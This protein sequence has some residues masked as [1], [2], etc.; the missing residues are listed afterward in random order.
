MNGQVNSKPPVRPLWDI[1]KTALRLGVTSFGGPVAHLGF[2]RQEYVERK[3]WLNDQ[4]YGEI[5]AI[6]QV[7]PGPTSSQVGMAIGL[8][9]GGWKGALLAWLGFTA[10]SALALML[11]AWVMEGFH[12]HTVPLVH[13]FMLVAAAVVAQAVWS[14]ARTLAADQSRG[15]LAIVAAAMVLLWPTALGQISAIILGGFGGLLLL[16]E[17]HAAPSIKG[18]FQISKTA[19]LAAF[20]LFLLLLFGLPVLH[21]LVPAQPVALFD[22]FYR[23]GS[24]VYGGGHVV[25][26][27]LQQ[28]VVPA[29]WLSNDEFLAGYGAAQAIPG[30]L[31]T[32]AAFVGFASHVAPGG[33]VGGLLALVA[34]FLPGLLLITAALPLYEHLHT[35]PR[36]RKALAGVNAAVVG[37]LGAALYNPVW[38]SA[39]QRPA[40]LAVILAAFGLLHLWKVPPWLVVVGCAVLGSIAPSL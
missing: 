13:G 9:R 4:V 32:F 14:M 16:R 31:F 8:L 15:T 11:F 30:P 40:D 1:F 10:P 17:D 21:W 18:S 19:G 7:L 20:C 24:L 5:V 34:I 28:Q 38:T 26:P 29:G 33:V 39:V 35:S 22:S 12:A 36:V 37:I 2:F 23:A 25:L 3:Q 27:L 6:S